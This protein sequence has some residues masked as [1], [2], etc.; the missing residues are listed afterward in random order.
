MPTTKEVYALR[1]KLKGMVIGPLDKNKGEMWV[2]CPTLYHKALRKA[3]SEEAGYERI[4]T[5][6]LSQYRKKRYSDDEL[7]EQILRPTPPPAKNRPSRR[8]AIQF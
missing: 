3:Y 5:A 1:K 6:K 2:A 8:P 4:Y 7:P